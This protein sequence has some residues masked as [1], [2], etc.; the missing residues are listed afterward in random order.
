MCFYLSNDK[1]VSDVLVEFS[2]LIPT[3]GLI[4]K[5]GNI[6][7]N[8]ANES[9]IKEMLFSISDLASKYEDLP[10]NLAKI[11]TIIK[12]GTLINLTDDFSIEMRQTI[13]E[14]FIETLKK[15]RLSPSEILAVRDTK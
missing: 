6:I 7:P 9:Q 14:T 5:A 12:R 8:S 4:I 3:F 11:I 13:G 15:R 10:D 1:T 2:N